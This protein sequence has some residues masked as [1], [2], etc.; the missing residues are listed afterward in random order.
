VNELRGDLEHVLRDSLVPWEALAGARMLVTGAT[1][2]VGIWLLEVL[3]HANREL[4]LS[5]TIDA[6][7]RS[8]SA[9]GRRAPHLAQDP[10]LRLLHGDVRTFEPPPGRWTHVIHAATDAAT[11]ADPAL[12]LET[13]DTIVTGTRHVLDL[14]RA[15]GAARFLLLSS[16]AVY[17]TQPQDLEGIGEDFT[18]G[19]NPL[20]ILSAY[21]EGKRLAELLGALHHRAYGLNCVS[22]RCFGLVGPHLPLDRHFAVGN[23]IADGLAG[24][25]VRVL[26]DG[27][28]VRSYLYA[29]DLAAWLLHLLIRGRPAVSYNVGSER[30]VHIAELA[31]LVA[32]RLATRVEIG[33]SASVGRGQHRYVPLTSLARA[34]LGL[35]E[36][37]GL[38]EALNRTIAWHRARSGS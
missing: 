10:A 11:P 16:G 24:R 25:P 2:F 8:P 33:G 14:A 28:A 1:G 13:L 38:E 21:G 18:G 36:E 23:F 5:L 32:E 12:A 31:A 22:A 30:A 9:F 7:S 27:T 17:G 29:A 4:G 15:R 3:L 26:G 6:L 20:Q 19:P 35:R 34:E 37:T